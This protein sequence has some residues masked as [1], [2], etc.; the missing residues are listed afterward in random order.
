MHGIASLLHHGGLFSLLSPFFFSE[1]LPPQTSRSR[2]PLEL[3]DSGIFF[4]DH[5]GPP[6]VLPFKLMSHPPPPSSFPRCPLQSFGGIRSLVL[7]TSLLSCLQVT[8]SF[9]VLAGSAPRCQRCG[10]FAFS[11]RTRVTVPTP[12]PN[13]CFS[14]RSLLV[15]IQNSSPS[16]LCISVLFSSPSAFF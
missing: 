2:P 6:Q 8:T 7:A 3:I 14:L 12:F 13:F 16:Y 10:N 9:S 5:A 15:H 1:L 4:L 11:F